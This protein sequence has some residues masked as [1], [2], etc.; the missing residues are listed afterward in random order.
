MP[1]T[2]AHAAAAPPL[3]RASGRRLVLSALVVGSMAPD[4][5][6]FLHLRT[7]RTIGH[8]IPGLF[9][10]CLPASL[11]VLAVWHLVVKRP[12]AAL[13]PPRLA[14]L[15]AGAGDRFPF[16]PASRLTRICVS[17]LIGS[18]SHLVWDSVTHSHGLVVRHVDL[19]DVYL[20]RGAHVYDVLQYLSGVVGMA[21]LIRWCRRQ[22]PSTRLSTLPDRLVPPG[23]RRV[24]LASIATVCVGGGLANAG[25]VLAAD[26]G[27]KPML[28]A[29]VVGAMAAGAMAVTLVSAA[30]QLGRFELGD[31]NGPGAAR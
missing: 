30:L 10:Q 16:W 26:Q 27:P 11:V 17:V 19:L 6:Y 13:L 31:G 25:R 1:F 7:H 4:F 14:A 24:A 9:L 28:V 29:A 8:T 5:E 3:W 2:V 21:L 22:L 23:T 18:L 15:G 12:A 20:G